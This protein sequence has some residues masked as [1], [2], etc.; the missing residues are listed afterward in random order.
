MICQL[1]HFS[2]YNKGRNKKE[3]CHSVCTRG[4][5]TRSFYTE[6]WKIEHS[7]NTNRMDGI[8]LASLL[9]LL[10]LLGVI[11][12]LWRRSFNNLWWWSWLFLLLFLDCNK[13]TDHFLGLDAVILINLKF[14]KNVFNLGLGHLVSPCLQSVF[15]HL[16]VDLSFKVI[17]LESLNNQVVGVISVSSHFLLEHLEHVLIGAGTTNLTEQLIKLTLRHE[18]SNI[19]KSSTEVVFVNG[20]IL[21]D[22]HQL[23]T[24]LVHLELL[25]REALILTL[26]HDDK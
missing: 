19:V 23:E 2:H 25:L 10:F 9:L 20:S 1:F 17:S 22:V 13:E 11:L 15:E 16:R 6:Q 7:L 14:S 18:D 12:F 26:A 24:V 8:Y 21:V 4:I 3:H 5:V